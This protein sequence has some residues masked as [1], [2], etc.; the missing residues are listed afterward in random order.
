[1][2]ING[3]PGLLDSSYKPRRLELRH[4]VLRDQSAFERTAIRK[5]FKTS[6]TGSL[7]KTESCGLFSLALEGRHS[8]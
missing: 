5:L 3:A 2:A 7:Y 6:P 1:M 8:S 4:Q